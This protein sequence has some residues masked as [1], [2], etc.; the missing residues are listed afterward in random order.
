MKIF[1]YSDYK[2]FV[3]ERLATMPKKGRGEFQ[4]IA[5]ALR[6]NTSFVSQVFGGYKDF[7]LEQGSDFC[8]YWGLSPIETDYFLALIQLARAGSEPLKKNIRRQL[9]E[10]SKNAHTLSH[11]LPKEAELNAA[12]RATFYSNWYYSGIRQLTATPQGQSLEQIAACF[13][14][15]RD[16]VRQVLQFLLE[17]GLCIERDGKI[18][19]GP[20]STHLEATSPLVSRHHMNW[21][22]KAMERHPRLTVDELA[23]TSPMTLSKKDVLLIRETTV[24]FIEHVTK[25]V[26]SSAS[27]ELYCMNLDW[28]KV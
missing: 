4:K 23:Y 9:V 5:Q 1:D 20:K 18:Q 11:R 21:R 22:L 14:L 27:E 2:R 8:I 3:R 17:S 25:I 15:P 10:I 16:L 6:V 24:R 19:T 13:D 7:N 28:F 12:D 26:D